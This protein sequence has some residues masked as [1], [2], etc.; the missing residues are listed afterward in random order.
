MDLSKMNILIGIPTFK[1]KAGLER[2]LRSLSDY[3]PS[4]GYS[5]LVVDNDPLRSAEHILD[6]YRDRFHIHY[7][8][9]SHPGVVHV[10]N[11]ILDFARGYEALVFLDDDEW[12]DSS[13]PDAIMS[14]LEKYPNAVLA[15]PVRY[16]LPEE[17]PSWFV[18]GN[19]YSR[20]EYPDGTLLTTTGTGNSLIPKKALEL[21]INERFDP[22]FAL[23]GGEDTELFKRLTQQGIEIRWVATAVVFESVSNSEINVEAV[24]R[25]YRRSGT[26]NAILARENSSSVLN[27]ARTLLRLIVGGFK[28]GLRLVFRR[29]LRAQDISTYYSGLGH[30]DV[31]RG[32]TVAYYG[33]R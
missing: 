13:W 7:D 5:I 23:I 12:I 26:V 30:L 24:A 32:H 18:N 28:F 31:L 17:A 6:A 16:I 33:K 8:V 25:R 2:L 9:E 11:R 3:L 14:S 15:G 10:R 19:F 21:L 1:R 27:I 20:K 4:T 22:N 29:P